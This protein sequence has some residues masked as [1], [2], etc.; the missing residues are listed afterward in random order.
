MQ[1]N[2]SS[3]VNIMNQNGDVFSRVAAHPSTNW[4]GRTQESALL[5]LLRKK[6]EPD[7]A[8]ARD[9]GFERLV[10]LIA[11]PAAQPSA[12]LGGDRGDG[13]ED[14]TTK[15]EQQERER[16]RRRVAEK[17]A[18][19]DLEHTWTTSQDFMV[20]RAMRY[21]QDE[22]SLEYTE[23][24]QQRG[25]DVMRTGLRKF[26]EMGMKMGGYGDDDD[27][28]E[29][30]EEDDDH[31][32][33][34]MDGAADAGGQD[35]DVMIVDRPPPPPALDVTPTRPVGL[36]LDHSLRFFARCETVTM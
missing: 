9:E 12:L 21:V 11:A 7:D 8:A 26:D 29:D 25:L 10:K 36:S 17:G 20:K 3:L 23:E 24:E 22:D 19:Q 14:V 5:Q 34:G 4:P 28:E 16:E 33:M 30:S 2:M 18:V 1:H 13:L 31:M 32:D 6:P 15:E 27:D 35:P